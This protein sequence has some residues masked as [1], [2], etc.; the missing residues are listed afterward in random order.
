M[1]EKY[2]V[3][4]DGSTAGLKAV[5]EAVSLASK[6][7]NVELHLLH[8]LQKKVTNQQGELVI[9]EPETQTNYGE[10]I[11]EKAKEHI[12]DG[13]SVKTQIINGNPSQSIIDYVNETK[14]S[15]LFVGHRGLDKYNGVKSVAKDLIGDSPCPVVVVSDTDNN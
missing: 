10:N 15:K 2:I 13:I 9:E 11:I 8:V 5:N 12:E 4:V 14:A 1:N 3:A 6:T 7:N